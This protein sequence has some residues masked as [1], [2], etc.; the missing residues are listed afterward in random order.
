M[1]GRRRRDR[2]GPLPAGS[3]DP[4]RWRGW[5]ASGRLGS[6]ARGYQLP[7]PARRP[8]CRDDH[9]AAA[10]LSAASTSRSHRHELRVE[11]RRR[12]IQGRP[13]KVRVARRE[14]ESLPKRGLPLVRILRGRWRRRRCRRCHQL[15]DGRSQGG[16]RLVVDAQDL[17][18]GGPVDLQLAQRVHDRD[19]GEKCGSAMRTRVRYLHSSPR[20]VEPTK[21]LRVCVSVASAYGLADGDERPSPCR[22]TPA[23]RT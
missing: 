4:R 2:N 10:F 16:H 12:R 1:P 23:M 11:R 19:N 7:G 8:A 22:W 17:G 18:A 5:A 21:F 20:A 3:A 6:L 14:M 15:L 13:R 9:A